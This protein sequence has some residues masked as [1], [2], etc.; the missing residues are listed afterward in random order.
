M[1]ASAPRMPAARFRDIPAAA[2]APPGSAERRGG[3]AQPTP[4]PST[5]EGALPAGS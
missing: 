2:D 3:A 1:N 4:V 5:M